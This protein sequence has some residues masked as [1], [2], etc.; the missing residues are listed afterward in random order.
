MKPI[1]V[2]P[3]PRYA[4]QYK[5]DETAEFLRKHPG[6]WH[7]THADIPHSVV[8]ILARGKLKDIPRSQFE[9]RTQNTHFVGGTNPRRCDLLL[10]YV[11]HE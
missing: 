10:R 7:L 4:S 8:S 2:E 9:Y 1:K 6:Q 3:K 11:G 5:W